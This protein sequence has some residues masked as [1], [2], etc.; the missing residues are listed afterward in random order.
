V[1]QLYH[2][3]ILIHFSTHVGFVIAPVL[4][5]VV[6]GGIEDLLLNER[7]YWNRQELAID[8]VSAVMLFKLGAVEDNLLLVVQVIF[9]LPFSGVQ[10]FESL[11]LGVPNF[12]ETRSHI[13]I[14]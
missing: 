12:I 11:F 4:T 3:A 5:P 13:L 7:F 8:I 2:S 10:I 9:K 6:L 14:T 1:I